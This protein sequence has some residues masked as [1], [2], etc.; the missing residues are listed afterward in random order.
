MVELVIELKRKGFVCFQMIGVVYQ[1][2]FESFSCPY[3][4]IIKINN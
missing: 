1:N 2:I 4:N 3:L